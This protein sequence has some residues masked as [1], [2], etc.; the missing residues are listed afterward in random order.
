MKKILVVDDDPDI[1]ELTKNRLVRQGYY[2]VTAFDGVEGIRKVNQEK[3]DLI[4]LDIVMP[5]QD[6]LS[7]FYQ[8]N[9]DEASRHIPV[10]LL[11]AKGETSSVIEAQKFGVTEYFIKPYDWDSLLKC[12]KHCLTIK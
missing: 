10:I 6:G 8:L 5:K 9:N 3:P 1:V 4:L 2:V 7:M 12:I 11:T